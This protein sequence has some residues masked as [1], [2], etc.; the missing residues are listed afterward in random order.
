M[1]THV[2]A[3]RVRQKCARDFALRIEP[4]IDGREVQPPGT[5]DDFEARMRAHV[6]SR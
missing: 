4:Q 2:I 1:T 3:V 5:T 6:L